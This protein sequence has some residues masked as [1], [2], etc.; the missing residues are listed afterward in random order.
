MSNVNGALSYLNSSVETF[1][2]NVDVHVRNVDASTRQIEATAANVLK[3]VE[4]FSEQMEKGE[5]KQIAHENIMRIDQIIKEQFGNYDAIRKT[6][7]GVVR[8]FDINLVRNSTIEEL[9]EELC[10]CMG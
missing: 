3:N 10:N 4:Y 9:S 2:N 8:D 5:Q 7:L 1:G 6:I